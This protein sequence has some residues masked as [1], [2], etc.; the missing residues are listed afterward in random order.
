VSV[1]YWKP[2]ITWTVYSR[3]DIAAKQAT[4]LPS[5]STHFYHSI[6]TF[7][8]TY[9][10]NLVRHQWFT[11]WKNL[12]IRGN[13]LAQMEERPTQ[14]PSSNQ[15]T[16]PLEIVF[17]RLRI[18]PTRLTHLQLITH[19]SPLSCPHCK[20]DLPFTVDHLFHCPLLTSRFLPCLPQSNNRTHR[21][22]HIPF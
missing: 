20:N 13:K 9:I 10:N 21:P 3:V 15:P 17:T 8:C 12:H 22:F 4:H 16:R 1:A 6:P 2:V 14:W 11:E 19:L 18:G 7:S 5:I